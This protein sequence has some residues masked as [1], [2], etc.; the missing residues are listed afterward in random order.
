MSLSYGDTSGSTDNRRRFLEGLGIS[1]ESLVCAKQIHSS[2]VRYAREE[3]RGRG[4]LS[5]DNAISDTDGLVT[6]RK[7]LALA[8]FTADCLPIF[9]FDPQTPAIGLAHAGWRST[10][11]NIA[12]KT[13]QLMKGTFG[14]RPENI[15][16]GLGPAIRKCCYEVGEEF[17]G[18]FA[19][20]TIKKGSRF[21][22]DLAGVNQKQVL[23]FGVKPQ[24]IFDAEIC[25][26]C[27]SDGFFS[28][29]REGAACGRM[30][31][32]IMLR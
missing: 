32:L 18:I 31:A 30:M 20:H 25:T 9:F 27:R 24:N 1:L 10:Q 26:S 7:N 5:Y 14:S 28:Y 16:V 12:S 15:C 19:G 17:N 6:D 2:C 23:D 13:L 29:R 8:I 22:L 4:A 11:E 3:D 21:C